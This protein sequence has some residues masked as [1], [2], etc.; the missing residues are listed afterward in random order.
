[1]LHYW[2]AVLAEGERST[3]FGRQEMQVLLQRLHPAPKM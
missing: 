2:Q 1:M 3:M